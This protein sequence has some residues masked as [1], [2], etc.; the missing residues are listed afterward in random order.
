MKIGIVGSGMIVSV[1]ADVWKSFAGKIEAK[2]IWCR[3]VSREQG[4][5]IAAQ[6]DIPKVYTDYD[7]FLQ[8]DSFDFV[9]IGLVNSLHYEYSKKALLAGKSVIC[10]K[11]FTSTAAQAEELVAIAKEKH[12]YVFESVLPWYQKNYFEIKDHL[13]ELGEIRLVQINFSQYSRRYESYKQGKVLPVFDPNLDGGCL[14]D[15]MVY[16]VHWVIGNLGVPEDVHYYP[17]IG[18]N[19]IDVSGVMVMDY[20]TFKA[21]LCS[22]KDSTSPPHCVIQGD[23]GYLIQ[24]DEPGK[25]HDIDVVLNKQ[26]PVRIDTDP[27]HGSFEDIYERIL[28]LVEGERYEKTWHMAEHVIDCMR[29]MEKARKE[30]GIVFSCD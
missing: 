25:C 29:V 30:A 17:N 12:L 9:Y 15:I 11:P 1:I 26:D 22:A 4:E 8:D 20:G 28:S 21:V 13:E 7:A 27:S 2:A 3:E 14:Y 10:E 24:H 18:Y 5:N 16:S 19:G 23:K 6:Y